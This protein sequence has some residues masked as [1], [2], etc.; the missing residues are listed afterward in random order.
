MKTL[1]IEIAFDDVSDLEQEF[2]DIFRAIED[3]E[4]S[5][6]VWSVKKGEPEYDPNEL[7]GAA[8]LGQEAQ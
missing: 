1:K 7:D 5:G 8:D 4:T 6:A 3:G 2:Q